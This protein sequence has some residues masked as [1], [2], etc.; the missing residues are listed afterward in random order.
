MQ[1]EE[2]TDLQGM[3]FR[4]FTNFCSLAASIQIKQWDISIAQKLLPILAPVR[5]TAILTETA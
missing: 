1:I 3:G 2:C 4:S 5:V